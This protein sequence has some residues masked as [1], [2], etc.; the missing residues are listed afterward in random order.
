MGSHKS[1]ASVVDELQQGGRYTFTR[2]EL[3]AL[4]DRSEGSLESGLR[5]LKEK[6]RI[7]SP[8]RG[9]YVIVP[10]EYRAAG[11]PPSSWFV[12]DLMARLGQPYY[13]GL[14]SAAAIHGAAHQQPMVLQVVTDQPTRPARIG[15]SQIE[16]H[17]SH[18]VDSIP[19]IDVQTE[20]GTMRV[21]TPEATAFDLVH[22]LAAAGHLGNVTT[23]LS[24]LAD[25][26]DG[27][28]LAATAAL[29]PTP[30]TQRLGF[31]LELV[32]HAARTQ[33]LALWL[34]ERR[35][36]PVP[37][38]AGKPIGDMQSDPRWK[39]IANEIVEADV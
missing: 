14:L 11:G 16:F 34:R 37:L 23:V 29:Y 12:D 17:S 20:T 27:D 32:G 1:W 10:M 4:D 31:L 28:A 7:A 2:R 26:L 13:V 15:R 9:F 3:Q 6:G 39:V 18:Q 25:E 38:T 30:D 21:S 19:A 8:R 35:R 24:E 22:Y 36:R 33:P 5:R